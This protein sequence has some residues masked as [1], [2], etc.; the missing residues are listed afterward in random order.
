[1]KLLN[2]LALVL[3]LAVLLTG[4][5]G[6]LDEGV[7]FFEGYTWEQLVGMALALLFGLFPG[8]NLFEWLKNKFGIEGQAAHYMVLGVSVLVT[9]AAMLVTGALDF[10]GFEITLANIL[11]YAVFVYAGS[12]VAYQKLRA[13]RIRAVT[14]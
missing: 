2:G 6:Q 7:P 1:M 11:N 8:V 10:A 3:I 5:S 12:Q 9:L 13:D 4:C 14:E